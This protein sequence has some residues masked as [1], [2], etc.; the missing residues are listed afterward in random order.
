MGG[1]RY[2]NRTWGMLALPRPCSLDFPNA[3]L[4][5]A[6]ERLKLQQARRLHLSAQT[7]SLCRCVNCPSDGRS[8]LVI[9]VPDKSKVSSFLR[10]AREVQPRSGNSGVF[11][12]QCRELGKMADRRGTRRRR[13]RYTTN[14]RTSGFAARL[15]RALPPAVIAAPARLRDSKLRS[16]AIARISPFVSG[17]CTRS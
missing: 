16:W 17:F 8:G 15:V 3:D 5:Q 6:G 12:N 4:L 2:T 1:S 10:D 9:A 11:Q 7:S 13:R 14:S